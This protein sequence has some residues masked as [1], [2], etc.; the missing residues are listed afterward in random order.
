MH[1]ISQTGLW[2]QLCRGRACGR[3]R[4]SRAGSPRSAGPKRDHPKF[5]LLFVWASA[6]P[7]KRQGRCWE[8]A[9]RVIAMRSGRKGKA[10]R[11]VRVAPQPRDPWGAAQ[12][13]A[14][15]ETLRQGEDEGSCKPRRSP[16]W[17]NPQGCSR[18]NAGWVGSV[19]PMP[20]HVRHRSPPSA[21]SSISRNLASDHHDQHI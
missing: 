1:E 16:S 6:N 15:G 14:R 10:K 11:P 2:G 5:C 3:G 18:N 12:R 4:R 8:A 9:M 20:R 17:A 7:D 21:N 13:S 19:P